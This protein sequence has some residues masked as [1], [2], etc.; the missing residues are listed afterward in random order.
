MVAVKSYLGKVAVNGQV[1]IPKALRKALGISGGDA[2]EFCAEQQNN[3]VLHVVIRRPALS[4]N[5]M[6]GICKELSGRP[7][8]N[9]LK[10]IDQE[11]ML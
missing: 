5:A 8:S 1:L 3:G 9:I 6:R 4:F 2:I 11:D 10:E 7:V